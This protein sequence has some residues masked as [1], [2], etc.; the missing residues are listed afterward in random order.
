MKCLTGWC[1]LL[2]SH[3]GSDSQPGWYRVMDDLEFALDIHELSQ[4]A[5]QAFRC[6]LTP[7][8]AGCDRGAV[9]APVEHCEAKG[10]G[11]SAVVRGAGLTMCRWSLSCWTPMCEPP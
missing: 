11:V 2:V 8:M 5:W 10:V 6:N 3:V 7:L 9:G 4:G 1:C